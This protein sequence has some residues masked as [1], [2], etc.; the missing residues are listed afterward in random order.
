MSTLVST[1]IVTANGTTDASLKTGNTN[2]GG[3]I[4]NSAGGLVLASNSTINAVTVAANGNVG[5]G[6][7]TP[8]FPIVISKLA[9]TYIYQYDGT[10]VQITGVNGAGLAVSGSF[11]STDYALYSNSTERMRIGSTGYITT[12]STSNV[13]IGNTAPAQKLVVEGNMYANGVPLQQIYTRSDTK[14]AYAISATQ[15]AVSTIAEMTTSITPR[16]STSKVKLTYCVSFE[17]DYNTVFR[18]YRWDGGSNTIIGLNT[19]DTNYWSGT[20]ITGYDA[21]TT[22]TPMTKTYVYLDSP[23]TTNTCTYYL[24]V[25]STSGGALNFYLNRAYSSTGASTYE[26]S[27]SQAFLEEI[28]N[29]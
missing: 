2:A 13:G 17:A 6:T 12:V 29:I 26:V 18:V 20:F 21:D 27:I 15:N 28:G 1:N 9:P 16:R 14:A 25:Q 19:N 7:A 11:S 4:V 22:T 3:V 10:G 8:G 23:A 24:T 5:V